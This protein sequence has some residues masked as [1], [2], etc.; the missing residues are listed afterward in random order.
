MLLI[1]HSLIISS[2]KVLHDLICE[3]RVSFGNITVLE[4]RMMYKIQNNSH[5]GVH[6][7]G[8]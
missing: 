3:N 1:F 5:N 2:K 6:C 7:T 8:K 4:V